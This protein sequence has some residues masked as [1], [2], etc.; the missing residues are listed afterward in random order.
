MKSIES[1]ISERVELAKKHSKGS[2]AAAILA[3]SPGSNLE[4]KLAA[5][6]VLTK[7]FMESFSE[8]GTGVVNMLVESFQKNFGMT[9]QEAKIAAGVERSRKNVTDGWV[10]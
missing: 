6:D 5:L 7:P 2:E 1:Q 8:G 9:L 3:E 4:K 10:Y